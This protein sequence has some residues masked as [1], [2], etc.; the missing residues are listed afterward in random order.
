M[1]LLGGIQPAKL[2]A[3]MADAISGGPGDDGLLQRFQLMIWPDT[4]KAKFRY[5]DRAPNI[6]N[7]RTR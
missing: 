1:S 4:G 2:R 7:C 5:V 6:S 3:H